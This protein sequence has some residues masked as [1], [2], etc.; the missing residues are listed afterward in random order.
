VIGTGTI[1]ANPPSSFVFTNWSVSNANLTVQNRYAQ[2]TNLTVIGNGIITAS[3]NGITTFYESGL[4]S[5]TLWNVTYD[6]FKNSSTGNHIGFDTVPGSH[7]YEV[8]N[9]LVS[10]Y[11]YTP[12][13]YSGAVIAGNSTTIT[14]TPPVCTIALSSNAISFGTLNPGTVNPDNVQIADTNSG[15]A[16]ANVLVSGTDWASSAASFG[17]SNTSWS[18]TPLT[19]FGTELVSNA[20]K[21]T[22]IAIE[23]SSSNSIYFGLNMPGAIAAGTY[24][25]TITIENSC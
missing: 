24:T 1:T 9:V 25:Q 20:L 11:N 22:G 12:S 23:P 5:G 4:P 2:T 10:G 13:S 18:Q 6:G 21:S 3:Y 19:S 17:V 14:F 15:D 8:G 7:A 16:V